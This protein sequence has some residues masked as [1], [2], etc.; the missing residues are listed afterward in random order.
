MDS[1]I[2][3]MGAEMMDENFKKFKCST[4]LTTRK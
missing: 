4:R 2:F 3:G 1:M